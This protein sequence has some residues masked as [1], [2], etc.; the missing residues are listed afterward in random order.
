M[1]KA[2]TDFALAYTLLRKRH[3]STIYNT[4]QNIITSD[5]LYYRTLLVRMMD[6][7]TQMPSNRH[8]DANQII[9]SA[10]GFGALAGVFLAPSQSKRNVSFLVI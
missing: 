9:R 1:L 3:V 6:G 8:N 7:V 5:P 2:L 10:L 4:G